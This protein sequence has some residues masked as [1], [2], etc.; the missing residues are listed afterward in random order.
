VASPLVTVVVPAYNAERYLGE[1]LDSLLSQSWSDMELVVID[2]ASSDRTAEIIASYGNRVR[3]VKNPENKGIYGT[4]NEGLRLARGRLVAFYHADDVYEPE[5]VAR[6]VSFFES[7]PNVGAVF[8]SDIFVDEN[9][10]EY[11]RLAL[12]PGFPADEPI[13]YRT[14]LDSLMRYKNSFLRCPSCMVRASVHEVVGPYR[15]ELFKNSSDLEMYLRIAR[16][17]PIAVLSAH[18][19]RYRHT[20]SQSS[21]RY[22]HLRT[23]PNRFFPIVDLQLGEPR[24]RALASMDALAAYEAHRA[25]DQLMRAVNYYI[26][27][28]LDR[29]RGL[30]RELRFRALVGSSRVQRGRLAVLYAA[31]WVLARL[32]RVDLI[33][34][35]FYSRWQTGHEN[36]TPAPVAGR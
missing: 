8:C 33:A 18:L 2:D 9:G 32:P 17:Y 20:S 34:G 4:M 1:A 25:E 29:T 31:L 24:V 12:P 22:H 36:V 30:L 13:E 11:G 26:L 21:S 28:D 19:F 10:R 23:D 14:V 5:I 27:R 3:A 16:A 7:H 6:Q 15:P 35:L